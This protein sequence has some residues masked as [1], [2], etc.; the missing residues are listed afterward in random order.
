MAA[1]NA[2]GRARPEPLSM[3]PPS[4]GIEAVRAQVLATLDDCA[5]PDCQRLRWRLHTAESARDLWLLRGPVFQIVASQHCQSL[6]AE[7]INALIPA[8]EQVLPTAMVT[9]V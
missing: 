9:R 2:W 5:G 6:A 3:H 1:W 7:R 8:F 4:A